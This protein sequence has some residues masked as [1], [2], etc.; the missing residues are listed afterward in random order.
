MPLESSQ[1]RERDCSLDMLDE[2]DGDSCRIGAS[3]EERSILETSQLS[4]LRGE[5]RL[6]Q[7]ADMMSESENRQLRFCNLAQDLDQ[8]F[9]LFQK[10]IQTI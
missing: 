3:F 4:A 8:S 5:T 10:Q 7:L 6:E 2:G 1:S 9:N